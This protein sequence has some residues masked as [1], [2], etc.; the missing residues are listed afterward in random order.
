MYTFDNARREITF[1]RYNTPTPWMNYLSN[2]VFHTMISHCGG[3]VAFY[4]S[5]QIWRI[6]H[7]R[8]F[9]LPTDRSGFYTYIRDG[10]DVWTPT[11]E[12]CPT[13]PEQWRSTHGM[14]YTRFEARRGGLRAEATYFVGRYE[15]CLIWNLKLRADTDK[16]I[17]LFPYVELGMME[18]IRELS[19]QCY[20]KHQLS[21]SN[22]GDILVYKY[23]VEM[24]PRPD[25][26]PLVYFA[27]DAQIKA[28]DCDR[29]EFVGSYRSEENPQA[30]ERGCCS[31]SCLAG[32][33]PCFAFEIPVSLRA[34]E[35]REINIF[36]GTGMTREEI[37]HSVA[38]CREPGFAQASLR[39]LREQWDDYFGH[40]CC[41]VPD[42]NAMTMA[43]IWNPYQAERNFQFSRNISY[44][45]TGTFRGVGFRDTA[46]DVLAMI[47]FDT[48]RAEEKLD[49][50]LGQQYADG[51]T[52]HYFFPVEGYEPVARI[53]SDNHLWAVMAV[54]ALVMEEGKLDYL[55][56]KIAW[57]DGGEATVWEHL[58]QSIAF[59]YDNIGSHGL[60]LMLHSDWNDML[61]KVCRE[62]RGESVMVAFMLG[63]ALRQMEELAGLL[64]EENEYAAQYE[65]MRETVN[66]IAW[67]GRWYARAT[68]D[69]GRFLGVEKEPQAKIW[70]NAQTW[71]VISG[72]AP[73]S[74]AV[75]AMDSVKQYLDTPL[76]IKKIHPAMVDYPTAED[77][78]TYYN[79][80]C[81]ENGSVFC[82]ANAWAVIAECMLGRGKNA[83]KYY[84]QLLPMNAQAKAGE[85]RY[86]AEPY[87]YSSNIFGPESD[88]FGLA[89]VSWLTGTSAWMYIAFTQHILGVRAR[90]DGL[91]LCPCLPP[92]WESVQVTRVFRGCR[93]RL[94]LKNGE[95]RFIPHREGRKEY[96]QNET[97]SAEV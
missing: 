71:A 66:Q 52:N 82:H 25:E 97:V 27:S 54:Y 39:A 93:Y 43:N 89:N 72:M 86:K 83:W 44:Y 47:P 60:P 48:Q 65:A 78:L 8:F 6:N 55:R 29:D 81:G 5:P 63:A 18:F 32:G 62:G 56:R 84:S 3:G 49:L 73:Q 2:G 13:K 58:K 12:P 80:G 46:Q 22:M 64:G 53:H 10:K 28:F 87:V 35:E 23:G 68:M 74:R 21:V 42:E 4:K 94:T 45:A 59:V 91:E 51:H 19:W 50:L 24:Q 17:T 14:G 16:H 67:D 70:L 75:Q 61:Y 92:E 40:F 30:V 20:N 7:Y 9:H 77:P 90:W 1:D 38:H 96:V 95:N 41:A 76:G 57:Y 26:T 88:K 11:N 85:W 37:L 69:D 36:L 34:G 79:K 33:D 15:N 31:N